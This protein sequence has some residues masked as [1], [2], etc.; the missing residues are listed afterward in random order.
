MGAD[1]SCVQHFRQFVIRSAKPWHRNMFVPLPAADT[2]RVEAH[3]MDC[4]RSEGDQ[5]EK[6]KAVRGCAA[7]RPC[8][9]CLANRFKCRVRPRDLLE[10]FQLLQLLKYRF[11]RGRKDGSLFY[12]QFSR[13]SLTYFFQPISSAVNTAS[14]PWLI[15]DVIFS[16]SMSVPSS[17]I[18]KRL[19][20]SSVNVDARFSAFL[21]V[22]SAG[23]EHEGNQ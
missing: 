22:F 12:N 4:V 13:S 3:D 16:V 17:P 21:F 20:Q 5:T 9:N 2:V 23:L 15:F 18:C 14:A 10:R 6:P 7:H 8:V 19:S 11:F 1:Q